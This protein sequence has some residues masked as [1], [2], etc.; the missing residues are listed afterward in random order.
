MS[1]CGRVFSNCYG[2]KREMTPWLTTTG[3]L[4]VTLSSN[5]KK[6]HVK[7]HR[8]VCCAFKRN[9]ENK[10][11]I[12]HKNGIKTDNRIENLEF[13]SYSENNQHA[14]SVLGKV[15]ALKGRLG[16]LNHN[17]K[18]VSQCSKDGIVLQVFSA[19]AE[20]ARKTGIRQSDISLVAIGKRKSAGGFVWKY[21]S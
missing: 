17:S 3:Y 12:N 11:C 13:S 4:C 5:A 8:L 20:A 6:K 2:V 21:A 19:T 9:L 18:Q 10:K 7:V 14:Y 1:S 15:G 16:E